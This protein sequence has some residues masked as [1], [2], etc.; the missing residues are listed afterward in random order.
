MLFYKLIK[1]LFQVWITNLLKII[2]H[3]AVW[4]TDINN[5]VQVNR[6]TNNN[7]IAIGLVNSGFQVFQLL[8][9]ISQKLKQ[10]VILIPMKIHF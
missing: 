10:I 1:N 7:A 6:C 4:F 5:P 2:I 3:P 8:I 9:I